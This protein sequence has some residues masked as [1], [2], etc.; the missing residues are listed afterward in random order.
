METSQREHFSGCI[1]YVINLVG[2][3][4]VSNGSITLGP[5]QE[6]P[7]QAVQKG[8]GEINQGER[9]G[10]RSISQVSLRC[11]NYHPRNGQAKHLFKAKLL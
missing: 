2:Q 11:N 1:H 6:T 3:S 8:E 4:A 5:L 10:R 9:G 7:L